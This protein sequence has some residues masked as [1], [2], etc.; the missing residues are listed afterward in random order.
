MKNMFWDLNL[1]F[2]ALWQVALFSDIKILKTKC[3]GHAHSAKHIAAQDMV[4]VA[5]KWKPSNV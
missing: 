1:Y 5:E 2:Y 4:M 3:Y